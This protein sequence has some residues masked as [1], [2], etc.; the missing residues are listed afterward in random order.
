MQVELIKRYRKGQSDDRVKRAIYLS[1]NGVSA[2][3]RNTG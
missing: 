3:L 2:G 1:I